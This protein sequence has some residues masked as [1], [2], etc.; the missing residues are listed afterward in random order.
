MEQGKGPIPL[1]LRGNAKGRSTLIISRDSLPQHCHAPSSPK[2]GVHHLV[3]Y[4]TTP[5]PLTAFLQQSSLRSPFHTPQ[6][7]G[8]MEDPPQVSVVSMIR[9]VPRAPGWPPRGNGHSW[10]LGTG[11]MHGTAWTS[12]E[13]RGMLVTQPGWPMWNPLSTLCQLPKGVT[14][15]NSRETEDFGTTEEVLG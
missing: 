14:C 10:A 3:V 8:V 11:M 4:P 7:H 12:Q 2:M 1:T 9:P 15:H 6:H 5:S 13:N